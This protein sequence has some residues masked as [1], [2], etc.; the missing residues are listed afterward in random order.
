MA[1]WLRIRAASLRRYL[2]Y[3]DGDH[4]EHP[5]EATENVLFAITHLL[6]AVLD[7]W[8]E[9]LRSSERGSVRSRSFVEECELALLAT[10]V[11]ASAMHTTQPQSC[12][13]RCSSASLAVGLEELQLPCE[14]CKWLNSTSSFPWSVPFTQDSVHAVL[15]RIWRVL[16]PGAL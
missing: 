9:W 4:N 14:A 13:A 15:L 5:S 16:T 3:G 8:A 10:L 6:P 2:V 12:K 1:E 11:R 7:A